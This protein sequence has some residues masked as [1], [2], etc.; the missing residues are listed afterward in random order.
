MLPNRYCIPIAYMNWPLI[1]LIHRKS[2][3]SKKQILMGFGY[4]LPDQNKGNNGKS[5]SYFP[6][7]LFSYHFCMR[8]KVVF[9]VRFSNSSMPGSLPKLKKIHHM[10]SVPYSP[11]HHHHCCYHHT[12]TPIGF[13][14]LA[15]YSIVISNPSRPPLGQDRQTFLHCPTYYL[16]LNC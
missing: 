11:R 16:L 1:C 5:S 7:E 3:F 10:Y 15:F 13:I 4:S 12:A 2:Q 6:E 8:Q 9:V 14:L